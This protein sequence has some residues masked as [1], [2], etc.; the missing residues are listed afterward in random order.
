MRREWELL[1][2]SEGSYVLRSRSLLC[3]EERKE[4]VLGLNEDVFEVAFSLCEH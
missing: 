1:S 3:R 2:K 4:F